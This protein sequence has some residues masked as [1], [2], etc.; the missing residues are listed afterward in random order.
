MTRA[1]RLLCLA[2]LL[3]TGC[4]DSAFREASGGEAQ[5]VTLTIRQLCDIYAGTTFPVTGDIVLAGTVTT[6]DRDGNFYRTLCI[7]SDG[8][9]LEI[10]AGIDLLH[11]DYPVGSPITLRLKGLAVGKSRGVLQIGRMPAAGSGHATDYFA[12]KPAL[13]AS[14]IRSGEELQPLSPALFRIAELTPAACGR[15]VRIEAV[16]YTPEDLSPGTWVGYKRFT[17]DTGAEIYTF[18]RTYA[19]FADEEVAPGFRSITGI[20]Q[21]NGTGRYILKPRYE[22]DLFH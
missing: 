16:R 18:V 6:C 9:G 13:D 12:S 2:A 15:L 4:Y 17:D 21:Q 3:L 8:A 19:R 14:V 1:R 22:E 7:E 10:M 5:P 20:L 11:N